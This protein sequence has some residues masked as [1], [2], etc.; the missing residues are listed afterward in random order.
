MSMAPSETRARVL[1]PIEDPSGAAQRQR[2]AARYSRFVRTAKIALPA[3]AVLVLASIFLSGNDRGG[4]EDM[5]S[6]EELARLGAGLRLNQPRFAGTTSTG[7]P[8]VLTAEAA[9][10]DGPLAREIGFEAPRGRVTLSD[11][12]IIEA[13]AEA[14]HMH[15]DNEHLDFDG[16]VLITTSDGYRFETRSLSID[17][18]TKGALAP[19]AVRGEGPQGTLEAG[20]LTILDGEDGLGSARF[21]FDGGVRLL[22]TPQETD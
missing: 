10:P 4:I 18:E 21:F 3:G 15:R 5:L 16:R 11:G 6:P 13:E 14:G 2:R 22:F 12:T 20:R 17:L 1:R 19:G 8:F 7:E 9:L